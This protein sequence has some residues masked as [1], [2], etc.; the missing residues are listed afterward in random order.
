MDSE[1]I[2]LQISNE[3]YIDDKLKNTIKEIDTKESG[4]INKLYFATLSQSGDNSNIS[5]VG[6]I[7][8]H[9]KS[10]EYQLII[11][12]MH[13]LE[14]KFIIETLTYDKR[15]DDIIYNNIVN[16]I[17]EKMQMEYYIPNL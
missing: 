3:Y 6:H 8:L 5:D 7:E 1:V 12:I 15:I 2:E 16:S 14:D 13:I 10:N 4:E 17:I 11:D 9:I